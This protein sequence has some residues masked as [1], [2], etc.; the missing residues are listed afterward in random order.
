MNDNEAVKDKE[1]Q[2]KPANVSIVAATETRPNYRQ[3]SKQK[4]TKQQ[5]KILNCQQASSTV[6]LPEPEANH[7]KSQLLD[8]TKY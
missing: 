7:Q 8:C 2:K 4:F 5:A 3:I 6:D 1:L